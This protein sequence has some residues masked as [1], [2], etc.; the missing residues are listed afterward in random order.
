MGTVIG[1]QAFNSFPCYR[2]RFKNMKTFQKCSFSYFFIIFDHNK[3]FTYV[4]IVIIINLFTSVKYVFLTVFGKDLG[5]SIEIF[6][7]IFD[8]LIT[9]I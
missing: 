6:I 3:H 5:K 9:M 8:V 2:I 4:R 7:C 1:T